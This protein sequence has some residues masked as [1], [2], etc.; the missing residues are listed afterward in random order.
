MVSKKQFALFVVIV[1]TALIGDLIYRA[2]VTPQGWPYDLLVVMLVSAIPGLYILAAEFVREKWM[3]WLLPALLLGGLAGFGSQIAYDHLTIGV[4][5]WE[6]YLANLGM[7]LAAFG[8][9]LVVVLTVVGVVQA[10]SN[11]AE[12]KRP[13]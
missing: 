1:M 8:V 2:F 9:F 5:R 13:D 11:E 6:R 4:I 12:R 7:M 10:R 3:R